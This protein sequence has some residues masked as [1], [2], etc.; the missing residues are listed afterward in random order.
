MFINK[1]LGKSDNSLELISKVSR[2]LNET[3]ASEWILSML[4][5]FI[6][7]SFKLVIPS[8]VYKSSLFSSISINWLL[9]RMRRLV[10]F[11]T[12]WWK[13]VI[14]VVTMTTRSWKD[15]S[16][17]CMVPSRHSICWLKTHVFTTSAFGMV[18]C[19]TPRRATKKRAVSRASTTVPIAPVRFN[20]H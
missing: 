20:S 17:R 10:T 7:S 13:P 9:T 16:A 5:V 6:L 2:F 14:S 4:L 3:K 18:V 19:V 1:L 12:G 11:I 8:N 15:C